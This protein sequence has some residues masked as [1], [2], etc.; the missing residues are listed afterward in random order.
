MWTVEALTLPGVVLLW[1]LVLVRTRGALYGGSRRLAAILMALVSMLTI[2]LSFVGQLI[3]DVT[4]VIGLQV[5]VR[6]SLGI[7]MG[8]C[9]ALAVAD[10]V[11]ERPISGTASRLWAVVA[12]TAIVTMAIAFVAVGHE[13]HG[14]VHMGAD[15]GQPAAL[16]YWSVYIAA[17]GGFITAV[18]VM[19]AREARRPGSW[20]RSRRGLVYFGLGAAFTDVYLGAKAVVLIAAASGNYDHPFV[21]NAVAVQAVPSAVAILFIVLGAAAWT[22]LHLRAR[23]LHWRLRRP[24]EDLTRPVPAVVLNPPL[25]NPPARLNRRMHEI[26]E[27]AAL[28]ASHVTPADA[29]AAQRHASGVSRELVLLELARRRATG[30]PDQVPGPLAVDLQLPADPDSLVKLFASRRR[31]EDV[32]RVVEAELVS[33]R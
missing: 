29:A 8:L 24:W 13:R 28:L 5:F 17:Y 9:A 12:T 14:V 2:R 16:T 4:G 31:A 23:W 26:R 21:T 20:T 27:A 7:L 18:A 15:S 3:D 1:V 11:R 10:V 6:D 33:T 32:A 30:A 19:A 22:Q 25:R